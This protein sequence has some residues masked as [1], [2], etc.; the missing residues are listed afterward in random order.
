MKRKFIYIIFSFVV[1]TTSTGF[2]FLES[3]TIM[4]GRENRQ[5]KADSIKMASSNYH[6]ENTSSN[7]KKE[8]AKPSESQITKSAVQWIS[9]ILKNTLEAL[10]NILASAGKSVLMALIKFFTN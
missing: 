7:L 2:G 5:M 8:S 9:K 6:F 1:L 3:S 4:H 10:G